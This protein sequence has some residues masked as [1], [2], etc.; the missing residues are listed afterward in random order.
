MEV[1]TLLKILRDIINLFDANG[2][3]LPNGKVVFPTESVK[4]GELAVGITQILEKNGVNVPSK[5]DSVVKI[6]PM[7]LELAH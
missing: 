7:I 2:M 3:L 6:L 4:I 1:G 5:V